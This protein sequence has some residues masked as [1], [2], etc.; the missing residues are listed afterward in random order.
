MVIEYS[1]NSKETVMK[2]MFNNPAFNVEFLKVINNDTYYDCCKEP[3]PSVTLYFKIQRKPT[4][5]HYIISIPALVAIISSL[6]TFW[7]PIR[8]KI[9][10][11]LNGISLLT[12]TLLLIHLGTELGFTSLNVPIAGQNN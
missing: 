1:D 4:L 5:Y 6:I 12:L 10:F 11:V 8:S 7:F 3:Y 2:D 9:R